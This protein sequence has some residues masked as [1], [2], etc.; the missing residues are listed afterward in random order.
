MRRIIKFIICIVLISSL[1]VVTVGAASDLSYS[2]Y[3]YDAYGS[4]ISAPEG[5]EPLSVI[6]GENL[7]CGAFNGAQDIFASD[8][9]DIFVADTGNNRIV[10]FDSSLS[11]KRTIDTIVVDG[12]DEPLSS[13]TGVFVRNG[14]MYIVQ[15][16][17][18]RVV[19]C[20]I[21]GTVLSQFLR[22]V[23]DIFSDDMQFTPTKVL[24]NNSGT[25][26]ILV[27]NFVYGALTYSPE[28]EFLNFYG[29]NKVEVS[30]ELLMDYFWKQILNQE[31]I[32][33]MKSYV[34]IEYTNF[35]IDDDNFVYTVTKGVR[36]EQVRRLNTLGENV[37]PQYERN[38]S[39]HTGN[40][41][42]LESAVLGSIRTSNDFVDVAVDSDGFINILDQ[43]NGRVF[44]Y[45]P[46]SRLLHI[47][48]NNADSGYGFK[49]AAA[50]ECVDDN[51]LILDSAKNT[52]TVFAPT[53]YGALVKEAVLLYNDG[54]YDKAEIKWQEIITRNNN[55]ELAYDG[56]GKA[57]YERGNYKEA[58]E[59]FEKAYSREGYSK[60]YKE[61]R[62]NILRSA[63]PF[64]ATGIIILVAVLYAVRKKLPVG[65]LAKSHT[66]RVL[67][68][69]SDELFEMKYHK[70]FKT[71]TVFITL[72]VFF[73]SIIFTRQLTAFTFNY[74][75]P[76]ESNMLLVLIVLLYVFV[77]FCVVNWCITSLLDGKGTMK[78]IFCSISY[79][80]IPYI[81]ASF[82]QVA[83]SYFLAIDEGMFLT[84]V[85]AIGF[86]WS[87]IL[88]ISALKTIH[89][90]SFSK[91]L[92][93]I[94]LTVV[95]VLILV[96][97]CV[98][99]FGLI[100][101]ILDFFNTIYNEIMY[102]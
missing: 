97:L 79:C 72:L 43:A 49:T 16:D 101:Q 38:V 87:G 20:D 2:G 24:V 37:L 98:L 77:S 74:N 82:I 21:N 88:L 96:F 60:A 47:F 78:E 51:I 11:F 27:K 75:N 85:T 92:L 62:S 19:R 80:L 18:Q 83:L 90:Y 57:A 15:S 26:F 70:R 28:G 99:F 46:E 73:V 44:Q 1:F 40:Y 10:V 53:E 52:I 48:G 33:Q 69:P 3:N 91:A 22:P 86:L 36:T 55:F 95:G 29:S 17:K 41:G 89:D 4:S 81:A 76:N 31:Q 93:S 45:D 66:M 84:V 94:F 102:R 63:L 39:S 12:V 35:C 68:H 67:T 30:L 6:R 23:A 71:R 25:V 13:P 7:E 5:Y 50:I 56:L 65:L 32:S 14:N 61:Y 59:Y 64:A 34:P 54:F 8:N 100:Q 42:D 58:M 9:G